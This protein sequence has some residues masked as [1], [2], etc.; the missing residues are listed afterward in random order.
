MNSGGDFRASWPPAGGTM[1]RPGCAPNTTPI[2][3]AL[4][5][6]TPTVIALKQSDMRQKA[7]SFEPPDR[8]LSSEIGIV[9]V[10]TRG[11]AIELLVR[12]F[13][14]EGFVTPRSRIVENFDRMLAD[15]SVGV[16]L[17]LTAR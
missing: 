10:K 9:T 1:V 11:A 12:F 17:R 6:W 5:R 3:T 16:R 4:L 7:L 13:R 14:E 8:S 15:P 2:I